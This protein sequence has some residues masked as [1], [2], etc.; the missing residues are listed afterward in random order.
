MK[1]WNQLNQ[2]VYDL[3]KLKD[4]KILTKILETHFPKS[5]G[6]LIRLTLAELERLIPLLKEA[7]G[8][9]ES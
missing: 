4:P 7:Y 3:V 6:K 2:E 1:N 8:G 9:S 5:K